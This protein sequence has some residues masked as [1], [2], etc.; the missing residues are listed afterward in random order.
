MQPITPITPAQLLGPVQNMR[1]K[2][3]IYVDGYWIDVTG[4]VS[5]PPPIPGVVDTTLVVDDIA[6]GHT[7]GNVNLNYSEPQ[8]PGYWVS[9]TGEATW[10]NSYNEDPLSG[11]ACCS[12][13]TANANAV[14][15]DTVY[16]RGGT[17]NISLHPA[18]S[19][20]LANRITWRAY[21][22][23]VPT[24]TVTDD[25][26]YAIW[27]L[28]T[29]YSRF[30]GIRSYQSLAF[31]AL[32]Y[33]SC[34]NEFR[35]CVFEESGGYNY[36]QGMIVGYNTSFTAMSPSSHNWFY[37]CTFLKY[38]EVVSE[39][40]S[41]NDLGS[42]ANSAGYSDTSGNNTFENCDFSHG[43]H[44]CLAIMGRYNV[45]KTNRFHNDESYFQDIWGTGEN[46][47]ASGYFGNR[48]L[49]FENGNT[50]RY[51][52]SGVEAEP[53]VTTNYPGSAR[54][55]LVEGNRFGHSGCPPDDDGANLIENAGIHTIIRF[56]DLFAAGAN[57][58]YSKAQ[59]YPGPSPA[60]PSTL[61]KSG[62]YSRVFNNSIYKS[63]IGDPDI[64]SGYKNGMMISSYWVDSFWPWPVSQIA[65]NNINYD[66]V[67]FELDTYDPPRADFT[68]E[69]NYNSNPNFVDTDISDPHSLTLPDLSLQAGSPCIGAGVNLTLA[70]GS[71]SGSTTLVVDDSLYFQDGTWG[72]ALTHGV[73]LFP[74]WI[75]I[76]AVGNVVQI[77]SINYETHTITLA[78]AMT[79][80]D[81]APIWL[82]KNS[83]GERV[84]Y[85]SAPEQGA[86]PYPR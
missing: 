29:S 68:Y 76:G 60:S 42:I 32:Y 36:S 48:C 47:P 4:Y 56:N 58:Y 57:G 31:F 18:H 10:S 13:A 70:S 85:G 80:A 45:I 61:L 40:G 55:N 41:L 20:T 6:H 30:I 77:E 35:D 27:T 39:G 78:S 65:K 15:G 63:G 86:H 26:R 79:W 84:L 67:N 37:N 1:Q 53:R 51:N 69:N 22:S 71:G 8:G 49:L 12:L 7:M 2:F 28:G 19:G 5:P 72:S 43:G 52:A 33:G 74:D 34:Y 62:S 16:F 50:D 82:Y 25:W 64:G 11:M 44:D 81:N 83:S 17:Y 9:P 46:S 75:A 59:P 21:G 14:A 73:T 24:F 38:G 66:W 54:D 23:E 3:E